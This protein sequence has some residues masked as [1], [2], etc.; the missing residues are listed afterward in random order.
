MRR[1]QEGEGCDCRYLR[2]CSGLCPSIPKIEIELTC[3]SITVVSLYGNFTFRD[4]SYLWSAAVWKQVILLTYHQ[5]EGQQ[6][7][8]V[9][10]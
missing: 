10:S 4:F 5:K 3:Y 2:R 6:W 7:P 9:T 1:W 8:K